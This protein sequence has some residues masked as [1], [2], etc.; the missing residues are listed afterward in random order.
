MLVYTILTCFQLHGSGGTVAAA[1]R[2]EAIHDRG[3]L[4]LCAVDDGK[5]NHRPGGM[6]E[7]YLAGLRTGNKVSAEHIRRPKST[8]GCIMAQGSGSESRPLYRIGMNL[9][10]EPQVR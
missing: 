10:G 6:S 7:R 8:L 2:P 4:E 1:P 5:A 3:S 9:R